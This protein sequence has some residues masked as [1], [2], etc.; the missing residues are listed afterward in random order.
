MQE[1]A[2]F[3]EVI[4][5]RGFLNLWI[6][7]ILVQISYNSLNFALLFWTFQL[8]NSTTAQAALLIAVYLPAVI[9]GLFAGVLV[10][11]VDKKKIILGI[12]ILL[13]LSF[14]SLVFFKNYY[15]AIL[16]ITFIV[17]SLAQFYVPC[18]SSAIPVLCKNRHLLVA[19]SLFST[20]LYTSFLLGFGLAGPLISHLGI[21]FVFGGGA[22]LLFIAFILALFFPPIIS[23]PDEEGQKLV[24]A[25]GRHNFHAVWLVGVTQVKNTLNMV[26]GK[27]NILFPIGI[28]AGVQVVIGVLGVI[29]TSFFENVLQIE[30]TDASYI[31]VI[32]LGLGM[33]I[34]GLLIGK[35]GYKFSKRR[36]VSLGI[37]AAGLM[38]LA[39]G[40][41]PLISPVIQYFPITKPL[42]F[43]YQPPLS[44]VLAIGSF[45][46]GMAMVSIIVPSQT[47]LQENT[48]ESNR[49]KV[50]AV[51]GVAMAG[52]S[53][54]PVLFAGILADLFGTMP[55][56]IA[57]GGAIAI[58]GFFALK[59]DFFFDKTHLPRHVIEFLGSGHWKKFKS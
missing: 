53:L 23:H 15:L 39:V 26:K 36:I 31:L 4:K 22:V 44:S 14:F 32:P 1:H 57:M 3:S 45:F 16:L 59:P 8:T 30:A 19:N 55:I 20:T 27:F 24:S 9:F 33:V 35:I 47:V 28:L 54:L 5:N 21:N 56:F 25:F 37:L 51:L 13:A 48:A 43:F 46:L 52:L 11:I 38:F 29:V 10:D 49:G 41:S 34:G 6:N 58:I 40:A 18:E 17:N 12:N 50:Y 42:P 7:Q 2:S